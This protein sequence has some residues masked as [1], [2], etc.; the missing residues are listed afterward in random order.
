MRE[1]MHDLMM[2]LLTAAIPIIVYYVTQALRR[3]AD[4]HGI[5]LNEQRLER[6]NSLL[7]NGMNFAARNV[8]SGVDKRSYII[9]S[10][11]EYANKHG[12]ETLAALKAGDPSDPQTGAALTARVETLIADPTQPTPAVLTGKPTKA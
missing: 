1:L 2:T 9:K 5:Q 10:A 7:V 11:L 3:V 12:A 4:K 6:L 8:P